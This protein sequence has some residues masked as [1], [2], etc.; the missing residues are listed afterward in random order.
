VHSLLLAHPDLDALLETAFADY[1]ARLWEPII[2]IT[3]EKPL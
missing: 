1:A 3:S 2:A